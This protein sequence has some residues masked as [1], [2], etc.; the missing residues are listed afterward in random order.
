MKMTQ[1]AARQEQFLFCRSCDLV[2]ASPM[3]QLIARHA[4][5][6]PVIHAYWRNSV[7]RNSVMRYS[8]L[9]HDIAA[10]LAQDGGV[11]PA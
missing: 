4:L 9:R 10:V 1:V 11:D 3:L 5:F 7:W 6:M 8:S 2:R